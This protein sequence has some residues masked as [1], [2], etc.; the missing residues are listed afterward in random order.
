MSS[1][2]AGV[3]M[4][5]PQLAFCVA[6]I[7]GAYTLRGAAGFGAGVV[8]IPLLLLVLPYTVVIPTMTALG[9]SASLGQALRDFR[10]V[11]WLGIRRLIAPTVAGIALG[12]WLF[13]L[14][15]DRELL[16]ACGAFIV[17]YA[18]WSVAPRRSGGRVLPP[19]ALA[20]AAGGLGALV[21]TVFGGMAGPFYAVYLS[22]LGLDKGRFRASLSVVLFSLGLL[23]ASGYAALG[24]YDRHVVVLLAVLFPVMVLAML[25]GNRWHRRL[26]ERL[27]RR[28]VAG[29]LV[30]SGA[31]LLLK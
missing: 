22:A 8:G 30:A 11:D 2:L 29:V 27:F 25:T 3:A 10:D 6:V 28:V 15:H 9:I 24:M 1:T 12:L 17:A 5:W 21:A 19:A 7:L 4:G 18:L 31:L 23:R 20:P 26:D 13:T 16:K 14:L